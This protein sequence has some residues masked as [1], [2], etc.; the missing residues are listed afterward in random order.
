MFKHA[1]PE[2]LKYKKL[3]SQ[4]KWS[5]GNGEMLPYSPVVSLKA[6]FAKLLSAELAYKFSSVIPMYILKVFTDGFV[7]ISWFI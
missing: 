3:L 6:I 4:C 1:I 5:T 7:H 2:N